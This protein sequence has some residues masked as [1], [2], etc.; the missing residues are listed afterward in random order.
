ME[1]TLKHNESQNT[2]ILQG[3]SEDPVGISLNK[4]KKSMVCL[5]WPD[6][7]GL[8]GRSWG[9]KIVRQNKLYSARTIHQFRST[10]L[11]SSYY[12]SHNNSKY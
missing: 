10:C 5:Y 1:E 7:N 11:H 2:G 8:S 3:S 6:T 4:G 9:K 12:F